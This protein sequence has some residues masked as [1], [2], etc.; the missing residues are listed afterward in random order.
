MSNQ[1]ESRR[2]TKKILRN[3]VLLLVLA[4]FAGGLVIL[5]ALKALFTRSERAPKGW[6]T[7]E[8]KVVSVRVEKDVAPGE[9]SLILYDGEYGVEFPVN[10]NQCFAWIRAGVADPDPAWVRQRIEGE[11]DGQIAIR[12]DPSDCKRAETKNQPMK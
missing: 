1:L 3:V 9:D 10:G 8:A 5:V 12:Y 6:I 11:R 7:T 2:G 4:A